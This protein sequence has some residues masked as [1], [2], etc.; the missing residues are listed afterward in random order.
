MSA[1]SMCRSTCRLILS[2]HFVAQIC[3]RQLQYFRVSGDS[4]NLLPGGG[5]T[6]AARMSCLPH[7]ARVEEVSGQNSNR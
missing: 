1:L 4:L 3:F 7:P 2:G 6:S 5:G